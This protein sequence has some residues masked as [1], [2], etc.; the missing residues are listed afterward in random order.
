MVD[1]SELPFRLLCRRIDDV[2]SCLKETGDD[3]VLST[4]PLLENPTLF[5]G[6]QTAEW[7]IGALENHL[8]SSSCWDSGLGSSQASGK[9]QLLDNLLQKLHACGHR[10]L[11]FSQM[12]QTLD[13]LQVNLVQDYQDY[14]ELMKYSYERLDGSIRA[15]ERFAAIKSFSHNRSKYEAQQNAA[16]VFLI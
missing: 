14:L 13:I 16:F 3:G 15:E 5:V 9:L 8:F 1:N 11:L 7:G 4:D 6:Y 2:H 10:V 12:T